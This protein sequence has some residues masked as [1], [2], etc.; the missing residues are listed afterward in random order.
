MPSYTRSQHTRRV[1]SAIRP[2]PADSAAQ[3]QELLEGLPA[4]A[5][6]CNA[7]GLIT[8]FN[9]EAERVWGRAPRL[10][11]SSDRF[12]GSF[13]LF[14]RTGRPLRHDECWMALALL[15]RRQYNGEEII[16][17]QPNGA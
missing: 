9:K 13:K 4:G 3:F 6:T 15:H 12:C 17:E 8:Y 11:H 1:V 16:V 7:D 10:N 14:D 2:L 5:Y